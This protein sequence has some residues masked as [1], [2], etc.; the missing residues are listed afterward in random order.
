MI[1][2]EQCD[3]SAIFEDLEAE[4]DRRLLRT[5]PHD[6]VRAI[7]DFE[8]TEYEMTLDDEQRLKKL[9]NKYRQVGWK[10]SHHYGLDTRL[11][12]LFE[13]GDDNGKS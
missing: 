7:L 9:L 11:V 13:R 10:V 1:K 6:F 5:F 12:I 3:G 2:P 4:I 8:M